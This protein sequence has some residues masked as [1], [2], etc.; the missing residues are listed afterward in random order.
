MEDD[1]TEVAVG[2]PVGRIL[3]VFVV[4]A[5]GFGAG[6][7]LLELAGE[8]RPDIDAKPFGLVYLVLAVVPF[9]VATVAGSVGAAAGEGY[10]DIRE[11]IEPEDPFG[12]LG[13]VAAFVLFGGLV[14]VV[15]YPVVAPRVDGSWFDTDR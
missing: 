6:T 13:Y 8:I 10:L 15:A 5:V 9:G 2:L 14:V 12:F 3:V 4:T 1:R 11:G 7:Y